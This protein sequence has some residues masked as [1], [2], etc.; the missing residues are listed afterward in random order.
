MTLDNAATASSDRD[1]GPEVG[2]PTEF[3]D[4]QGCMPFI[5]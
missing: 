4:G 3:E 5:G 2:T 1:E